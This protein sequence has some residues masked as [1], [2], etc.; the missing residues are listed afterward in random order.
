MFLQ[1]VKMSRLGFGDVCRALPTRN[2]RRE[3][4]FMAP[5]I[6]GI[7]LKSHRTLTYC[8]GLIPYYRLR[9]D[10][11]AQSYVLED[12]RKHTAGLSHSKIFSAN[13][14]WKIRR[15]QRRCQPFSRLDSFY[16]MKSEGQESWRGMRS[17]RIKISTRS[18]RSR[19]NGTNNV[20]MSPVRNRSPFTP[21][22]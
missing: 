1:F 21:V 7:K 13:A 6:Y 10:G 4:L 16:R 22:G 12:P 3:R 9:M 19:E 15:L 2:S 14:R 11:R 20:D 5:V 8:G 17:A 18:Q